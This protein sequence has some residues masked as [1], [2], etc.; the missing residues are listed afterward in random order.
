SSPREPMHRWLD[1]IAV[2]AL[3]IG[4][5]SRIRM[6]RAREAPGRQP[7]FEP[8]RVGGRPSVLELFCRAGIWFYLG[9]PEPARELQ[10]QALV[11]ARESQSHTFER[12][13]R[14][15]LGAAIGE[16]GDPGQG[17]KVMGPVEPNIEIQDLVLQL[18]MAARLSFDAGDMAGPLPHA[19]TIQARPAWG[20]L[21]E[22]RDRGG[23]AA[24]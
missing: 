8:L 12:W 15:E 20:L 14:R 23:P 18:K 17:L 1:T 10:E 13:I 3:Y 7:L 19:M 2:N 6:F 16:L 11:L 5:T 4:S 21:L 22:N 9:Y 24:A